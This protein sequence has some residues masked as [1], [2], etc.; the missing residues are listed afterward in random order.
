MRSP[1]PASPPSRPAPCATRRRRLRQQQRRQ[2]D[3]SASAA[4]AR[5]AVG[6][7]RPRSTAPARRSPR[8]IYQQW[9]ADLKGKGLTVNYQGV[10]S[11]AGVAAA[12]RGHRRL[13]RLRS[14]AD[15]DEDK[16]TLKKGDAGPDPDRA[17]A[18][19]PSPTTCRGV[20]SGPQARR[21][22]DRRHLPRQDHEV[23]RPG[24]RR[25]RTRA[26][27]LPDTK[28]TVVHRSD[29]SGTTKGFTAVP[30]RL[31]S[32]SGRAGPG[33]DKNV[34]WPTGTGAKGNDGVAAAVK[35]TDGAIGYVEQAYALQNNF[36]F[37]DV[38]NK[39]RQVHRADARVDLGRRRGPRRSRPTSASRRSTRP[40]R[41]PTRSSRRRSSIVYK[42]PCKA[43][44]SESDGRG[45]EGVPRPTASAPARTSTSSCPTR[46]CPDALKAKDAGRGRRHAVQRRRDLAS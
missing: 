17:S 20:K 23:E 6:R 26:S 1:N 31:L 12:R 2:L 44:M 19:S 5:R 4:A 15:A 37:A 9:G 27:S 8:P 13:R 32:P 10:G 36:T 7:Q 16:A 11:G 34:K 45:P 29:S 18:R 38:K 22:D 46:R 33:V 35:Q 42:D 14:G 25:R 28:I 21:R 30:G 39:S 3:S 43:G 41:P 24:D 40:T